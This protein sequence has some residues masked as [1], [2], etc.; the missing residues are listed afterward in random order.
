MRP[1]VEGLD[2][3]DGQG[4]DPQMEEKAR[5]LEMVLYRKMNVFGK[6]SIAKAKM[7]LIDHK[8]RR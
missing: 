8:K 2:D 6:R 4:L 3:V 1:T 5:V 7:K